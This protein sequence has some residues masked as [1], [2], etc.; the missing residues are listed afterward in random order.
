[1][2]AS[3]YD[4]AISQY[5]TALLLGPASPQD[6]LM[7]RSNWVGKGAWEGVLND[8]KECQ[9]NT[10]VWLVEICFGCRHR[11]EHF[12][13]LVSIVYLTFVWPVVYAPKIHNMSG[14]V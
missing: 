1:M 5:T 12:L 6:L 10:N 14:R 3:Q 8:A 13:A 7:K 2:N 11:C 4:E 9:V